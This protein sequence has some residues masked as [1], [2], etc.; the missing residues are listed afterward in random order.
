[1]SY[2]LFVLPIKKTVRNY[3]CRCYHNYFTLLIAVRGVITI[4]NNC[5]RYAT[6]SLYL[7]FVFV[8]IVHALAYALNL[9]LVTEPHMESLCT[10]SDKS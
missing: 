4:L 9:Y 2:C 8:I 10:N 3:Y 5:D 1:M 7:T 6:S